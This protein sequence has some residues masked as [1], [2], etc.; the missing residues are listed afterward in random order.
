MITRTRGRLVFVWHGAMLPDDREWDHSVRVLAA[1]E[2][3]TVRVLVVTA[4]GAPTPSQQLRLSRAVGGQPFPVA[5]VSDLTG[6]RFVASAL[7]LFLKRLR[8]F[9][10]ADR[11]NAYVHLGLTQ[12]EMNGAESF[13]AEVRSR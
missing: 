6:V 10:I 11:R 9:T 1:Q 7:A 8:T 4:G 3:T 12:E 5:V 2:R 13:F